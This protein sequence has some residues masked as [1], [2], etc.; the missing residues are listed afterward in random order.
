MVC[1]YS[2]YINKLL[3]NCTHRRTQITKNQFVQFV[4]FFVHFVL[5]LVHIV[6]FVFL[7]VLIFCF[8]LLFVPFVHSIRVQCL[9]LIAI[10]DIHLHWLYSGLHLSSH[11]LDVDE[12]GF[13]DGVLVETWSLIL[14]FNFFK[15]PST[16]VLKV[17]M[18]YCGFLRPREVW[19][20]YEFHQ[21]L[22]IWFGRR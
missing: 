16:V 13:L 2:V 17:L 15:L 12:E 1:L 3:T 4:V 22:G 11:S 21:P 8:V 14:S 7:F 18:H 10:W 20:V 9:P 19:T 5:L 6:H